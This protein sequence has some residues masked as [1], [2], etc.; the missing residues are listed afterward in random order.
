MSR[1]TEKAVKDILLSDYGPKA[2][3]TYPSL[4][5]FIATASA[6][7]SRVAT[8]A[9]TKGLALTGDEGELIERWLAAHLYVLS[10][11]KYAGRNGASFQGQTGM[12]LDYSPYG[13]QAK[14]IDYS[15]C[16]AT[17]AAGKR[18][19]GVWWGGLPKSEQTSYRDRD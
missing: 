15:G 13:Q 17:I 9:T 8:C 6:I 10:D 3:G 14:I 2:D 11:Q 12:A 1:T 7:V 5:P 4:L 19:V 16:L 18:S